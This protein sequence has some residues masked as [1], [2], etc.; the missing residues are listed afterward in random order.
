MVAGDHGDLDASLLERC[1]RFLRGWFD[2]VG[3]A[4]DAGDRTVDGDD[5]DGVA[6]VE[7]P[8]D[9]RTQGAHVDPFALHKT[10]RPGDDLFP[11]DRPEHAMPR[12]GF[13]VLDASGVRHIASFRFV[14]DRRADRMAGSRFQYRIHGQDILFG[15]A[16]SRDDMR[17]TRLP[18]GQRA[19]LVE[20]DGAYAMR[21]LE[22]CRVAYQDA[23]QRALTSAHHDRDRGREPHG[24]RAGDDEDGNGVQDGERE[25]GL[26]PKDVPCGT[27]R[28]SKDDDDRNEDGGDAVREPLDRRFAALGF[29]HH[30]DDVRKHGIRADLRRA[31]DERPV[32][33]HGGTD[34][35]RSQRLLDGDALAGD[36]GFVHARRAFGDDAVDRHLLARTDAD[37]VADLHLADRDVML[38]S[39]PEDACGLRLEAE[40]RADRFSGPCLRAR[41]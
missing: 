14:D 19:G 5:G 20:D 3:D 4:D 39:V 41:F 6:C 15:V 40:E 16:G 37:E 10:R 23:A 27:R 21:S 38:R 28:Y 7:E 35:G 12:H 1:D 11:V 30:A 9:A 33:I 26:R 32:H 17:D 2:R 18:F 36:H 25:R 34:D 24:A 13:E 31:E 8:F 22:R 29:L